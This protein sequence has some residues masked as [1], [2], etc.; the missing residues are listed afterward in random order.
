MESW[1][2]TT[3]LLQIQPK[4]EK[5]SIRGKWNEEYRLCENIFWQVGASEILRKPINEP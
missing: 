3:D 4:W 5:P 1:S 2:G